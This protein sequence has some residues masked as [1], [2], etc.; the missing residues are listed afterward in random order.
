LLGSAAPAE[1]V[2]TSAETTHRQDP[3]RFVKESIA[4]PV[5]I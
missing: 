1:Q 2:N 5:R 4:P 3:I